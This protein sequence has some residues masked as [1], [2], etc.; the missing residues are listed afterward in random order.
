MSTGE[1]SQIGLTSAIASFNE[2]VRA[3]QAGDPD[4]AAQAWMQAVSL[5]PGMAPAWRNLAI[6][7]EERGNDSA[8]LDAYVRLLEFD[9]FD[10]EALIRGASAARRRGDVAAAIVNYERA[11]AVYPHF[12]FW[13]DELAALC[14]QAGRTDEG[15]KWREMGRDHS[16]DE[17]E[18]AFEDGVRQVRA[19][20]SDLGIAIFEAVI[21][22]QP[23]NIDAHLRIAGALHDA[24]RT[25]DAVKHYNDALA[26]TGV[27][28]PLVLFHRALVLIDVERV[29]DAV[30]DLQSALELEP[31]FG[32]ARRLLERISGVPPGKPSAKDLSA[33][34]RDESS[35]TSAPRLAPNLAVP[36][37]QR[38]WLEQVRFLV[39]QAAAY[40]SRAGRP[41]RVAVLFEAAAQ[42]TPVARSVLQLAESADADLTSGGHSRVYFIEAEAQGGAG[43]NGITA[44]GWLKEGDKEP[45]YGRWSLE[46]LG[47]PLDRMLEAAQ[48]AGGS[49]GF[50]LVLI[51][52]TGKIR[53]DQ[54]SNA[55]LARTLATDQ[56]ALL[57][58]SE[59]AGDL[60]E[61]LAGSVPNLVLINAQT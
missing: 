35:R 45:D 29:P 9:P 18:M 37:P 43:S 48:L 56:V 14:D 38:P 24:G 50:N 36:D 53:P 52:S 16:G 10:T 58:P 44:E 32:R 26:K 2:G 6:Y 11:I 33:P 21:E 4:A 59:P 57:L 40:Q 42:L 5:D 54:G 15:Q 51:V 20:N 34:R 8:V 13:Y 22:E 30:T 31:K 61:T 60:E 7:H 12:R 3:M 39:K 41:G 49:D 19:G 23:G 17:A 28:T 1:S 27:A 46:P 25:G 47:V 55:Q